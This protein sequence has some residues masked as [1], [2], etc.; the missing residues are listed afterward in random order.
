MKDEKMS[1]TENNVEVQQE[2]DGSTL[3]PNLAGYANVR[4]FRPDI[5]RTTYYA[6]DTGEF[7]MYVYNACYSIETRHST[8]T[9]P[10]E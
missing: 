6:T 8:S 5:N 9:M 2:F 4:P 7:S 1:D 10:S 3:P